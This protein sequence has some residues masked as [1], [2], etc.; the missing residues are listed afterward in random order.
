MNTLKK[1]LLNKK[2]SCKSVWFMRQAGRYLPEFRKIRSKNQ[3]FINLCLDSQLSSEITLQPIKRFDIDSAIIFS[4]ILITPYALGQEVRFIKDQG[5]QLSLFNMERFLDNNERDFSQKLNPVYKAIEITRKKLDHNKSLIGFIGAPWTLLIYMMEI[6]KSKTHIDTNKLN[7]KI[8]INKI[9]D[10]L[11][12]FLC[13]HIQNQIDAG[14]DVVQIFDSWAGLIPENNIKDYC[15]MPNA[16]IV[17]FC[18]KKKI[19]NICF[20]RGIRKKYKEFNQIVKPDGINLDYEL[21]PLWAKSNLKNVVIQGGLDPKILLK[22]EQEMLLE[23]TKYIQIFK[24]KPYVFNL[25][26]G[27][28]PETDPD[29]VRKLIEFYRKYK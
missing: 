10:R 9:L 8:D 20:P 13:I 18:K 24:D 16:K 27:L 2:K 19:L 26:H 1:I 6:K 21:D 5:P 3:N 17:E 29:R 23:A 4:D 15:F 25:G 28:L 12:K 7:T 11:I 22:S 14:A